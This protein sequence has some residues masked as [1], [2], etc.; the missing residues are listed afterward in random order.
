MTKPNCY[1][2]VY[3]RDLPG[4]AH[5]SCAHPAAITRTSALLEAF[6]IMGVGGADLKG[7]AA[8]GVTGHADGIRHSWFNWPRNFDP[9]WLLTCNGF[10]TK[11]APTPEP[12]T[13]QLP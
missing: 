1:D 9:T 2:C 6:A 13:T 11:N 12:E 7:A 10:K 8:L 5:S 3:R 4:S